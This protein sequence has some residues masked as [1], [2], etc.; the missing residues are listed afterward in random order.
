MRLAEQKPVGRGVAHSA[1]SA[2]GIFLAAVFLTAC[3]FEIAL[4]LRFAPSGGLIDPDAYMRLV[5]LREMIRVGWH[6]HIVSADNGGSG[7]IIYWS[8]LLDGV[9]LLIAAPLRLFF[10]ADES[11]RL[12][13]AWMGPLTAGCL[14]SALLWAPAPLAQRRWLCR[15]PSSGVY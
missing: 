1:T 12:S 13:A 15:I 8:H 6:T 2:P 4:G 9:A 5:R 14:G 3:L 11:L 7:T 10:W